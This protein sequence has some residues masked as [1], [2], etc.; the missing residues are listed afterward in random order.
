LQQRAQ[1]IA[2]IVDI[3]KS[4]ML[5]AGPRCFEDSSASCCRS[6]T[7][8]DDGHLRAVLLHAAHESRFRYAVV[9]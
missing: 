1:D 4:E 2:E 3:S 7:R 8:H 9:A 6:R 5:G